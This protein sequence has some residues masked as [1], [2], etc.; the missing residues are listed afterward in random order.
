VNEIEFSASE[1][2]FLRDLVGGT[3][4]HVWGA[5]A[6]HYGLTSCGVEAV[7]DK[8]HQAY[9]EQGIAK[10]LPEPRA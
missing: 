8:L 5:L 10:L 9:V 7:F 1:L 3:G 2:Q 4:N 6:G